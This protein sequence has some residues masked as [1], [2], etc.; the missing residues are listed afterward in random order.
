MNP[1]NDYRPIILPSHIRDL[2]NTDSTDNLL[3]HLRYALT[4][5]PEGH[6]TDRPSTQRHPDTTLLFNKVIPRDSD[7]ATL[8]IQHARF[9]H[10]NHHKISD[11]VLEHYTIPIQI[12][13]TLIVIIVAL[14]FVSTLGTQDPVSLAAITAVPVM[15]IVLLISIA[16]AVRTRLINRRYGI[17]DP[18][19]TLSPEMRKIIDRGIPVQRTLNVSDEAWSIYRYDPD[20]YTEFVDLYSYISNID[21]DTNSNTYATQRE[22][23]DTAYQ[24]SMLRHKAQRRYLDAQ[25]AHAENADSDQE[26]YADIVGALTDEFQVDFLTTHFLEPLQR[27]ERAA[28]YIYGSAEENAEA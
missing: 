24:T 18:A 20:N 27:Q 19:A 26:S 21:A 2:I 16:A 4:T 1:M 11:A 5:P 8:F 7:D 10:K 28:H 15:N 23:L 13:Y 12:L 6:S 22:I 3:P 14:V 25:T 17:D 9:P